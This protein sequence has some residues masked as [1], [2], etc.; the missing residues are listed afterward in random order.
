VAEAL[1]E[2]VHGVVRLLGGFRSRPAGNRAERELRRVGDL[3]VRVV[4]QAT[5]GRERRCVRVLDHREAHDGVAALCEREA[6]VERHLGD[7]GLSLRR[8]RSDGGPDEALGYDVVAAQC[9]RDVTDRLWRQAKERREADECIVA[10]SG[11][12]GRGLLEQ[13]LRVPA[14]EVPVVESLSLGC[15]DFQ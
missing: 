10:H 3:S 9:R 13:L 7:H 1:E 15:E 4:Y 5:S 8:L 14:A 12:F 11:V 2:H 6:S